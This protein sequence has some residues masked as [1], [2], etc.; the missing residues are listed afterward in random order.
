MGFQTLKKLQ[1][2][3]VKHQNWYCYNKLNA[4]S[5]LNV[6][7]FLTCLPAVRPNVWFQILRTAEVY[8]TLIYETCI[9]LHCLFQNKF[10]YYV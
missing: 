3:L 2:I 9:S 8:H 5:L 7:K 1:K 6:A 10:D 4:V